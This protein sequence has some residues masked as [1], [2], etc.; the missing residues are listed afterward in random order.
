MGAGRTF[1]NLYCIIFS[2]NSGMY[3]HILRKSQ[4]RDV[5]AEMQFVAFS[6]TILLLT[7]CTT[8]VCFWCSF[9]KVVEFPKVGN[10]KKFHKMMRVMKQC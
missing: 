2:I 3:K 6:S 9:S 8:F 5:H 4:K 7:P 1:E 10:L